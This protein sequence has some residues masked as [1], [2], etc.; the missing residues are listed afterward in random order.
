MHPPFVFFLLFFQRL[1]CQEMTK[2]AALAP[3]PFVRETACSGLRKEAFALDPP[4]SHSCCKSSDDAEP[5]DL[6]DRG[7]EI[8]F[9]SISIAKANNAID[10]RGF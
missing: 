7:K 6:I 10:P 1:A 4:K 9:L 8:C 2:T 5:S 3:W